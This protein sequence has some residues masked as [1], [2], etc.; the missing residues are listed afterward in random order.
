MFKE[1]MHAVKL[2]FSSL[3][4]RPN[5]SLFSPPLYF[6]HPFSIIS[7]PNAAFHLSAKLRLQCCKPTVQ[8]WL[9]PPLQDEHVREEENMDNL[10][11]EIKE[12][13]ASYIEGEKGRCIHQKLKAVDMIQ[14]LGIERFFKEQVKEI[15]HSLYRQWDQELGFGSVE[16]TGLGFRLL[17]LHGYQ[18]SADVVKEL[19]EKGG[20]AGSYSI[21]NYEGIAALLDLYRCSQTGFPFESHIM[22]EAA[23]FA[24]SR[25]RRALLLEEPHLETN[26]MRKEIEFS[27][28]YP[29]EYLLSRLESRSIVEQ[30][31]PGDESNYKYLEL[32]RLDLNSLHMLY[33]EEIQEVVS[34]WEDAGFT[35]IEFARQGVVKS[36]FTVAASIYEPE[37]KKFRV[38]YTK[39]GM[40]AALMDDIYDLKS[41]CPEDLRLLTK[42]IH[43]WDRSILSGLPKHMGVFFNGINAAITNVAEESRQYKGWEELASLHGKEAE[44]RHSGCIPSLEEY[45]MVANLSVSTSVTALSPIF[46]IGE[47]ISDEMLRLVGQCSRFLYHI[48]RISRLSNDI[49]T[50]EREER[51]GKM[52]SSIG[53]FM[54]DYPGSTKAEAMAHLQG[55]IESSNRELE[56]QL[57]ELK[58]VVPDSILRALINFGRTMAL[59]Y[60]NSDDFSSM[61][62]RGLEQLLMDFLY[63]PLA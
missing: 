12:E 9:Q 46:I 54:K 34:W 25:L 3:P 59:I 33:A 41:N 8:E 55:L 61:T 47:V 7:S 21:E 38:E 1:M 50:S 63:K 14:R 11:K 17:R 31:W 45:Q 29:R 48:G 37:Y 36:Y 6:P 53:C 39:F 23:T 44:W 52:A 43:R 18:V 62:D 15:M 57:F 60:K 58:G 4:S 32:A 26:N 49:V 42:A 28:A 24:E 27:L 56:W 19:L 10:V 2:P 35:K 13:I 40:M 22:R 5:F 20:E 30:L 51:L 16:L